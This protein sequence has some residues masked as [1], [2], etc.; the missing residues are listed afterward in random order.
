MSLG[1]SLGGIVS[2]V[3]LASTLCF[4]EPCILL[5]WTQ[6]YGGSDLVCE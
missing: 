5:L 1:G 2:I 6:H 4:P 3:I